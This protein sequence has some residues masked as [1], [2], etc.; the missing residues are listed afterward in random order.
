MQTCPHCDK[1][2]ILRK[3]RHQGLFT[4]YRQCP[5]C[6][7]YF[8]VDKK[9]KQRQA[10]F[11]PILLASLVLT[12]LFYFQSS[13][14]LI[15]AIISYLIIGTGLYWANKRVFLIPYQKDKNK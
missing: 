15:P 13:V 10:V 11:I 12:I 1:E 14:W 9:T 5:H 3:L 7:G 4:N 6:D 2:I 8:T